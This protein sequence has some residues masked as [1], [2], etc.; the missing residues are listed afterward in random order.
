MS[1]AYSS[2]TI[3]IRNP[4]VCISYLENFSE[5]PEIYHALCTKAS[6]HISR[7]LEEVLEPSNAVATSTEERSALSPLNANGEEANIQPWIAELDLLN[8]E[9]SD[10]FDISTWTNDLEYTGAIRGWTNF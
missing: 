4:S 3:L 5:T 2:R 10:N 6:K 1:Q 8:P 9:V 7:A